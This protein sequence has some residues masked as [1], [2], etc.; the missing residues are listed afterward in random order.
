MC[1]RDRNNEEKKY[2]PSVDTVLRRHVQKVPEAVYRCS[3]INIMG[4]RI[5]SLVFSTDVAIIRNTNADGVI[6][7]Y[8]FTPE[9]SCLL[10]TSI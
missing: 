3:G 10:Y 8:P 4:R 9:L 7:V 2:I 1:I 5:K 6:A